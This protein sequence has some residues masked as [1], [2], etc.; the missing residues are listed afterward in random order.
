[1]HYAQNEE[2]MV[3]WEGKLIEKEYVQ[4]HIIETPLPLFTIDFF[5]IACTRV[6]MEAHRSD[7]I[8]DYDQGG[9]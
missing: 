3:D 4:K 7:L 5:E 2:S 8:L 1:M 6:I 9:R